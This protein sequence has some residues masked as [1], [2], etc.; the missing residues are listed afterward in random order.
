MT[1]VESS[2]MVQT[3]FRT[4]QIHLTVERVQH[5]NEAATT[6]RIQSLEDMLTASLRSI[7]SGSDTAPSGSD[8][9]Q[10]IA[11]S[12]V[13]PGFSGETARSSICDSL[14]K[15]VPA[16]SIM[17]VSTPTFRFEK[18][19]C[20]I[21]CSCSCHDQSR[22]KK[23]YLFNAVLHTLFA[24]YQVSHRPTERCDSIYCGKQSTRYTYQYTFPHWFMP[25][26]V[27]IAIAQS[28]AR[29]PE[30]CLRVMNLVPS[31]SKIFHAAQFGQLYWIR[32]LLAQKKASVSDIDEHGHTP[33]HV[34]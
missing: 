12:N 8:T 25:R 34:S 1:N 16:G 26:A 15:P 28:S 11:Q 6:E 2:T 3:N 7:S 20:K 31:T 29:G 33:L 23:P 17:Q 22:T 30:L 14:S 5:Q 24:G 27:T 10:A 4:Q 13:T 9:L 21:S 32:R 18:S 19:T